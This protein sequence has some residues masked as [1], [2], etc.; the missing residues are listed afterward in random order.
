M[1]RGAVL[2]AP[3]FTLRVRGVRVLLIAPHRAVPHV[4]RDVMV[5]PQELVPILV[6]FG[7]ARGGRAV[8]PV[9]IRVVEAR[10]GYRAVAHQQHG[11]RLERVLVVTRRQTH[12]VPELDVEEAVAVARV[13][14]VR[15]ALSRVQEIPLI[16]TP[17]VRVVSAASTRGAAPEVEARTSRGD[18]V[19]VGRSAGRTGEKTARIDHVLRATR[20]RK[21]TRVRRRVRSPRTTTNS[22]ART[23]VDTARPMVRK[24]K[25]R[26]RRSPFDRLDARVECASSTSHKPTNYARQITNHSIH[27]GSLADSDF[28]ASNRRSRVISRHIVLRAT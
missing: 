8:L 4:H 25:T 11:V 28:G 1:G 24:R 12:A 3:E 10:G 5:R 7:L 14:A 21:S 17:S 6:D 27:S 9:V 19:S 16:T 15:R 26:V 23:A 20:R 18:R 13:V 22:A 2:H